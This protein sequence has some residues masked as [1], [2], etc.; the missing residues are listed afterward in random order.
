MLLVSELRCEYQKNPLG[1]DVRSPRLSW[2][3]TSEERGVL[4]LS[5]QIQVAKDDDSFSNIVWDSGMVESDQSH[6]IPYEGKAPESCSRYYYRVRIRDTKGNASDWSEPAYW[7]MGFMHSKEWAAEWIT[8]SLETD[9]S[10]A[11]PSP[12][13]R[14]TF[15]INGKVKKAR[16]YATSLGLYELHLNGSKIG[17]AL[18]TPGWT[19][20]QKRLQYQTYD[21]TEQLSEHQNTIGV[22]LADGWYRGHL[23]WNMTRNTYGSKLAALIQI[24]IEYE[25]GKI[26]I[27]NSDKSWKSSIGPILMSD[28]YMGETYDA[29]LEKEG[30]SSP[31]YDDTEWTGV[32]ILD[33]SKE[34]LIAQ[35]NVPVRVINE[36]KPVSVIQSPEGDTIIDMGQN[37]VGWIRFK[38]SGPAGTIVTLHHA[39]VLDKNNNFYTANLRNAKQTIQYIL[40]GEPEETFE[41]HFTFQ[42]FRYVKVEGYPTDAI[43][44][45]CFSGMV[46][47]S[48]MEQT[49]HFECSND[50][51]NQLQHNILWGQ[52][53]N[54]VDVPTDC[55]QRDE[56]LGWT[57]D[58]Q[59]FIRT[60]CFNMNVAPFFTKWLKDLQADQ[61]A[62]KGVPWVIPHILDE[63]AFSSAAW[64]DAAVI[65]PW[66]IYLCY[67]DKRILEEQYESMK[68]WVEYLRAQGTNEYLW[69]TGSHFGDW[70]A[71]DAKA[72]DDR[73][74]TLNEYIATAFYAYSTG[75]FVK[76]A[77]ILGK[78][79]DKQKYSKLY[80]NILKNFREEFVTPNGRIAS[81][82]Q[83]AHVLALMF[84]L[85]E[86]KD[87]QKCAD[88]LAAYIRENKIHLSTGFVGTPYLCHVLSD[89]GYTDLAYQLLLQTEYPSWLYQITKGATTIWEHWDGIKEDGSF[90]SEGMNSY[91]HYAYGAI[92]DWLYRVVAGID[93]SEEQPGYKHITIK[94]QLGTEFTF[95]EARLES[96]FGEIKSAW[97]KTS[98]N[99]EMTVTIPH[100]TTAT[101]VLP[102][103]NL[104]SIYENNQKLDTIEGII[105]YIESDNDV[106]LELGSGNY[107]F[108]YLMHP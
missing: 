45:D 17:D 64:G 71:L 35:Q 26:E 44:L 52:K 59:V 1:I 100:N 88:T 11:E 49:G 108:T 13:L 90:W 41:P 91:N 74:A 107:E 62:E 25:D 55:P 69:D 23:T 61:T 80:D 36:L 86:E 37:M 101:I 95:A 27:I 103:A 38:V 92:G 43:P 102:S 21:I 16:I 73:G 53:G 51:V 34:I 5:Y 57:G 19:S 8:P 22:I 83:T 99:M 94:P 67:G 89:H 96:L 76:I 106:K 105:S 85:L 4:Q 39:E 48:D 60:A 47:H 14:K 104:N 72:N 9:P 93:T 81:P 24:Q 20:Y 15:E 56:R 54:F 70:L 84:G 97:K 98:H 10:K 68:L 6:H 58:A 31:F 87:I 66:T 77:E 2:K 79:D 33:H 29:R 46:I 63:N 82:T 32:S 65:C 30:W 7:E 50:L 18:L 78:D 28:I 3:I 40:K 12:L 42:G 75:L